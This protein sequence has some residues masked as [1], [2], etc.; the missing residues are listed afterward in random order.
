MS[1]VQNIKRSLLETSMVGIKKKHTKK[2]TVANA[3]T[4]PKMV[5]P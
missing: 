2:H 5:S 1:V 3:K 4:S